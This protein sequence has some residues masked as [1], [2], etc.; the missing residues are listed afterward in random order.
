MSSSEIFSCNTTFMVFGSWKITYGN[1]MYVLLR[2][3][4]ECSKLWPVSAI[5]FNEYPRLIFLEVS[6]RS[7]SDRKTISRQWFKKY[8]VE[9]ENSPEIPNPKKTF[10]F[11]LITLGEHTTLYSRKCFTTNRNLVPFS[12]WIFKLF[13]AL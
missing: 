3:F 2:F 12:V 7:E 8:R 4:N 11:W 13:T 1:E 10:S 5:F 6:T 9:F